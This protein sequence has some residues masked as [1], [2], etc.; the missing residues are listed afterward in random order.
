M[1]IY[2]YECSNCNHTFE[3]LQ[4]IKDE[5]ISQCPHCYQDTVVRLVSPSSFRLVGTGWYATDYKNPSAPAPKDK[6]NTSAPT[7]P[8]DVSPP[9]PKKEKE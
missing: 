3:L 8:T 1:P 2:E 5:P 6:D 4:K 9:S 7:K